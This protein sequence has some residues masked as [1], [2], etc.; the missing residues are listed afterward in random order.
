[1]IQW[2]PSKPAEPGTRPF[3]WF[4]VDASLEAIFELYGNKVGTYCRFRGQ[5]DSEG[6]HCTMLGQLDR[7][8]LLI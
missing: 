3:G 4:G 8:S 6:F 2:N 7:Y 1:M 5:T